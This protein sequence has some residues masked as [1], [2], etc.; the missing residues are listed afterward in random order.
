MASN[1]DTAQRRERYAMI[2]ESV[3]RSPA[4][5]GL[6][7]GAIR[8][9]LALLVHV[10]A[11]DE[12]F[13]GIETLGDLAV[14]SR[15]ATFAAIKELEKHGFVARIE[16]GGG[17]GKSNLYRVKTVHET[18]PLEGGETVHETAPLSA[19]TVRS[20]ARNGAAKRINGAPIGI[21]TV[22]E[23]AP[24]HSHEHPIDTPPT[25][26]GSGGG[27]APWLTRSGFRANVAKSSAE[28]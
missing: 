5:G 7:T 28:A 25:P 9:Y 27:V 3:M 14:L 11:D 23:T 2:R 26:G 18:A 10:N 15:R 13:P 6:S 12:C 4:W 21:K 24:E 22:H 8:V 16:R 17:R 20:G 19:E 1:G